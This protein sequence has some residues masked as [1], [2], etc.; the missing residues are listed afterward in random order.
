MRELI[1]GGTRSGKSAFAADKAVASGLAVT[2]VA[3]ATVQDEEMEQRVQRHRA[4]RPDH[5][6][7]VETPIALADTLREHAAPDRCVIV[8]CL[9][10]WLN[11]VLGSSDEQLFVLERQALLE[12]VPQLPG[13]ILFVSNEINMGVVP[14]GALSRRFCDEA[15]WLHQALAKVC[16]RVTLVVAGLPLL[17]KEVK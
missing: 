3:T 12:V 11:N 6:Q 8:D 9:T 10:L 15:G 14:M 16:D 7:L 17:L 1:L 5:W 4:D 2:Y 13:E